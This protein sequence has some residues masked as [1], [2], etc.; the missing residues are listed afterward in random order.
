[1]I[2]PGPPMARRYKSVFFSRF[3][4]NRYKLVAGVPPLSPPKSSLCFPLLLSNIGFGLPSLKCALTL[5]DLSKRLCVDPRPPFMRRH[6]GSLLF[7]INALILFLTLGSIL[8]P[9]FPS[10][11]ASLNRPYPVVSFL[12]SSPFSSLFPYFIWGAMDSIRRQTF[13]S[14]RVQPRK[15]ILGGPLT[16]KL[17]SDLKLLPF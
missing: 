12:R 5:G 13:S 10:I 17:F 3:S 6:E 15:G 11:R 4:H 16:Q 1:M 9:S 8:P 2:A 7:L 14:P